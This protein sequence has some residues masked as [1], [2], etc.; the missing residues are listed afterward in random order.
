[1][2]PY[3]DLWGQ[4]QVTSGHCRCGDAGKCRRRPCWV[5]TAACP[6]TGRAVRSS[7]QVL[8]LPGLGR[9]DT[10]TLEPVRVQGHIG[11]PSASRPGP[12]TPGHT[13]VSAED[14]EPRKGQWPREREGRAGRRPFHDKGPA[15]KVRRCGSPRAARGW[16]EAPRGQ[17]G[18]GRTAAW[19]GRGPGAGRCDPHRETFRATQAH[20][21]RT[22]WR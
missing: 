20:Q 10:G 6:G 1:M 2:P 13:L 15:P 22:L 12:Q 19:E 8:S 4:S 9:G 14:S 21:G 17:A 11:G 16:A 18:P 7:G 3:P 5:Q